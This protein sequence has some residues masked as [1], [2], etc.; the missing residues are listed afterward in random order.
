MHFQKIIEQIEHIAP[1]SDVILR[2]Q[3]LYNNNI[4]ELDIEKLVSLIESDSTLSVNVLKMANSPLY[5]FS[6]KIA[7]VSQAV[8]LFGIMQVYAFIIKYATAEHIQ[9]NTEIFGISNEYFNDICNLQSTLL[10]EWYTQI[11]QEDAKFLAPLALI[12]EIGK[13]VMANEVSV[14]E[15]KEE[16]K[17]AYEESIDIEK[18]EKELLGIS[19]YDISALVFKHWH[20]EPMYILLLDQLSKPSSKSPHIMKYTNAL[21]VIITSVNLKTVLSKE[22]VLQAC[23]IVKEMGLEPD[24]FVQSALKVK[25]R[26]KQEMEKRVN[27]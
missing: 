24:T 3:D 20:L 6:N 2:I 17:I 18:C 9:A 4:D 16:F 8:T 27:S 5:G 26:Y 23:K 13:L 21:K 14:S 11:D 22:S 12:M 7:T 19:S 15:Y 25:K 1:L 10:Y